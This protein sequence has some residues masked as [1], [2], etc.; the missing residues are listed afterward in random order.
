LK[1]YFKIENMTKPYNSDKRRNKGGPKSECR[2]YKCFKI[3]RDKK[4]LCD[5]CIRDNF[6]S[7]HPWCNECDKCQS[8]PL[9]KR[10]PPNHVSTGDKNIDEYINSVHLNSRD[11]L[12]RIEWIDIK[13]F[14]DIKFLAEGG[15]AKVYSAKWIEGPLKYDNS[16]VP[17]KDTHYRRFHPVMRIIHNTKVVLK[18]IKNSKNM[19]KEFLNELDAHRKCI[20]TNDK[21]INCYG[22]TFIPEQNEYAFVLKYAEN[23]NIRQYIQKEHEKLTWYRRVKLLEGVVDNLKCIHSKNFIHGDLHSGNVLKG[24]LVLE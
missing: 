4:V 12:D 8:V 19:S 22:V 14:S 5:S 3:R 10:W 16:K 6:G 9:C 1:Y 13:Q 18:S 2:M 7:K 24:K 11:P 15:F 20:G 17:I 21:G 23:G